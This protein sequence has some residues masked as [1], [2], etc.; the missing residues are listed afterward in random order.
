MVALEPHLLGEVTRSWDWIRVNSPT[1]RDGRRGE[2][3]GWFMPRCASMTERGGHEDDDEQGEADR[4]DRPHEEGDDH[5]GTCHAP[6]RQLRGDV[7][8]AKHHGSIP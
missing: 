7:E 2:S 1:S 4:D 8:T 3:A 6:R 5:H